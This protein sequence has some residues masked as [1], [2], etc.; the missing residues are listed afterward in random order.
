M[1]RSSDRSA[2][3]RLALAMKPAT[4][5]ALRSASSARLRSVMSLAIFE[6]P[7]ME[8]ELPRI[9]EIVSETSIVRLLRGLASAPEGHAFPDRPMRK[10]RDSSTNP[11]TS[12]NG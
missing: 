12:L 7:M 3:A 4:C 11:A 10:H 1:V 6:A 2:S 8:P 9:G 5:C